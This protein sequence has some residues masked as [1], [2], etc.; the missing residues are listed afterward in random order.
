MENE[1]IYGWPLFGALPIV[2]ATKKI[3]IQ[4]VF[5]WANLVPAINATFAQTWTQ[6]SAPI[7]NWTLRRDE[8]SKLNLTNLLNQTIIAPETIKCFYRL[9]Y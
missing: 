5:V 1:G 3:N 6:T 9:K 2:N 8:H 7:K 4:L